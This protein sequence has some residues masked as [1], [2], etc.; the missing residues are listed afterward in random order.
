[1]AWFKRSKQ[2]IS[3]ESQ[4]RNIPDGQWTKCPS[5]SEIIHNKQLELNQ[6][7]CNNCEH[8]FRIGSSEYISILIDNGTFTTDTNSG[9]D[10]LDVTLS[11]NRSYNDVSTQL[12]VGGDYEGWH[13]A[14]G[15]QFVRMIESYTSVLP[16]FETTYIE[17]TL[18]NG[19]TELLGQT[20]SSFFFTETKGFLADELNNLQYLA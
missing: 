13:Y 6:W 17:G 11:I 1:M 18:L 12:G 16:G 7:V 8:H 20:S 3:P 2:N 4:K 5:C 9:L 15:V 10:W 14:T 19:L